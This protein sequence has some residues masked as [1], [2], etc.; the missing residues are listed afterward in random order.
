MNEERYILFDQYLQGEL[1]VDEKNNFEKQ[2]SE[3]PT[4]ASA[5]ESFKE[6]HFQ[7]DNK[8]GKE[9]EREIFTENL[10]RISDKY[11][12]KKKT[13]VV[14]LKPWY[15]AAAASVTIMFGL[16]FFDYN[17]Y[18][19]FEDY[20]HPESAYFTERSVSEETL[21]KAENDFNGKRYEK[22]IPLFESIL[23]ENNSPEIK[24]FYGVSLLQVSKY[25]KAETIFKELES[26][27]SVFKE[28]AKW[29]LALSK[30]KQG[31]YKEC[32]EIL[33][34]ISQDYEDYDEVEHLLE[35]LE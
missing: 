16:F 33:Q 28:K 17:H 30:L 26:G 7:L 19:N 3:D 24:Y 4:L 25:V 11:F 22:A 15:F 31:K 10:T 5:F 18:P 13:K 34:T 20:N 14:S 1:T 9:A 27:N 6:M 23:K 29:N 2:L 12:N 35:E 8:F 21:K 32:K